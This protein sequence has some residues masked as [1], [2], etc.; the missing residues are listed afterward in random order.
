MGIACST[1]SACDSASL[2]PSTVLLKIGLTPEQAH[3]S[4]RFTL[5]RYTKRI[6]LDY[7]VNCLSECVDKIRNLS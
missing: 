5:G 7:T 4:V 1:G 3:C 2:K 6:D